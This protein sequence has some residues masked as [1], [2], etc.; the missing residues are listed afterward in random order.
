MLGVPPEVLEFLDRHISSVDQLEILLLL[1]GSP[2]RSWTPAEVTAELRSNEDSVRSRLQQ[3][4]GA[5]LV[6]PGE[7]GTAG[8]RYRTDGP[9]H[10]LVGRVAESYRD[11]RL[12]IIERIFRKPDGLEDFASAFRFRPKKGE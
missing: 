3:L 7:A 9:S 11:F 2:D 12:R 5:G 8:F 10:A 1:H 6:A 4:A